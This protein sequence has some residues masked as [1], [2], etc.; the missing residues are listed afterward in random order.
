M[1]VVFAVV[2]ANPELNGDA[3]CYRTPGNPDVI[4]VFSGARFAKGPSI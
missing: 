2:L 4:G 3:C 1:I